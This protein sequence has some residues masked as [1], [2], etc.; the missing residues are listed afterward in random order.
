[1]EK[2]WDIVIP[3]DLKRLFASVTYRSRWVGHICPA[4]QERVNPYP[5]NVENRVR[6]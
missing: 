4:G 1:M 5:A 6:S 3:A 2:K